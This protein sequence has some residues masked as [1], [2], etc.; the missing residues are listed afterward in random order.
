MNLYYLCKNLELAATKP[1]SSVDNKMSTE[2]S[3]SFIQPPPGFDE[4]SRPQ[5]EEIQSGWPCQTGS[6]ERPTLT[7]TKS[8]FEATQ[9]KRNEA[10]NS[11]FTR[12]ETH[13]QSDVHTHE[14]NQTE[15][16]N[17]RKEDPMNGFVDDFC[18]SNKTFSPPGFDINNVAQ[19]KAKPPTWGPSE[20][21]KS[22]T[23]AESQPKTFAVFDKPPSIQVKPTTRVQPSTPV[24]KQVSPPL[25]HSWGTTNTWA[26]VDSTAGPSRQTQ[27]ESRPQSDSRSQT[28]T[29]PFRK[30]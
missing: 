26:D 22:S 8:S 17:N 29:N 20:F 5:Q 12:S 23:S 14:S 6:W 24:T 9:E 11:H 4:P 2:N 3:A 13:D 18:S 15:F 1:S 19:P 21:P 10:S 16:R 30:V 25:N 7:A 27:S 28:S